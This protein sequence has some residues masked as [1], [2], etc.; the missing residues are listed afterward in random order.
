M[1]GATP[2]HAHW[3]LKD[4]EEEPQ[5]EET[6]EIRDRRGEQGARSKAEH[7]ERDDP[8][9]GEALGDCVGGG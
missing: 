7:H 5:R 9:G 2:R 1:V 8:G 3:T 4:T 6:A